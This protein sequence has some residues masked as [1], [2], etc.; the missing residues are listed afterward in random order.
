MSTVNPRKGPLG[1]EVTSSIADP[2]RTR[3][4]ETRHPTSSNSAIAIWGSRGWS[5]HPEGYSP[6]VSRLTRDS[7]SG[8]PRS[9]GISD[10]SGGSV[11]NL[12]ASGP[13]P[14]GYLREDQAI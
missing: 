14:G 1:G 10:V 4:P 12:D 8:D 5:L 2:T 9:R 3:Y 6:A 7:A 11:L 13:L